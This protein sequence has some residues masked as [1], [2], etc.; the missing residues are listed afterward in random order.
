MV[1][2]GLSLRISPVPTFLFECRMKSTQQQVGRYACGLV[3]KLQNEHAFIPQEWV[4]QQYVDEIGL[5]VI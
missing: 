3:I 5:I 4:W 1:S 2:S